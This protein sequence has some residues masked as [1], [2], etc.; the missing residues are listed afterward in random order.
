VSHVH[1]PFS[2]LTLGTC[3]PGSGK[4]R[5]INSLA[6]SSPAMAW[7]INISFACSGFSFRNCGG[8]YFL[9]AAGEPC[10]SGCAARYQPQVSSSVCDR[11]RRWLTAL[12]LENT[13]AT[14]P[15]RL[16]PHLLGYR[17]TLSWIIGRYIHHLSF[18]TKPEH[19]KVHRFRAVITTSAPVHRNRF[20]RCAH[21]DQP[22]FGPT[23]LLTKYRHD[24]SQL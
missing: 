21:L 4:T 24:R 7:P 15:T 12:T 18:V 19:T 23:T 17:L 16:A 3:F 22:E 6:P 10:V 1:A 20:F 14:K 5:P 2:L 9:L 8:E 11:L 13:D